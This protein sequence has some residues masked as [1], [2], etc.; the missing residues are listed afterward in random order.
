M[1]LLS[2][3]NSCGLPG[4]PA[5]IGPMIFADLEI[6][7]RFEMR[8]STFRKIAPSGAEE[9]ATGRIFIFGPDGSELVEILPPRLPVDDGDDNP[10]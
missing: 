6:G 8:G 1:L 10:S 4:E 5:T 7:E 2:C 9:E 3:R